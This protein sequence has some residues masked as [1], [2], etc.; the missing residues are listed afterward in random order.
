LRS[1]ADCGVRRAEAGVIL[2]L[3]DFE[4]EA[5]VEHARISLEEFTAA[6]AYSFMRQT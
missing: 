4:K 3:D 5:V 6:V 2:A 1:K